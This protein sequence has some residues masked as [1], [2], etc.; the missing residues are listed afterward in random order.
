[1]DP[2]VDKLTEKLLMEASAL[3]PDYFEACQFLGIEPNDPTF[4]LSETKS[5]TLNGWQ[6]MGRAFTLHREQ[7]PIRGGELAD[8]CGL[9]TK[10]TLILCPANI[11]NVW[12]E[13][14]QKFFLGA[15][16]L[17]WILECD[18]WDK[19]DSR[20]PATD[21]EENSDDEAK[22]QK[23]A[24]DP[25]VIRSEFAAASIDEDNMPLHLLRPSF[26]RA[27]LKD[28][29]MPLSDA[30]NIVPKIIQMLFLKHT[31]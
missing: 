16:R 24:L 22:K 11:I 31:K 25:G 26:F 7:S 9:V 6:A 21:N 1:M 3:E 17:A 29:D 20:E 12:I 28:G 8:G 27:R 5:L 18:V 30:L 13:E 4:Q 23:K 10:P 15:R 19:Q 14:F 2:Q